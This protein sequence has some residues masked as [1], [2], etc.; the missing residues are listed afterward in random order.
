MCG[1][2]GFLELNHI[3][4]PELAEQ[5]LRTMC[6]EMEHRGPDDQGTYSD[7]TGAGLG[8]VRLSIIDLA[9]GHQPLCNEDGSCWVALNGEIYNFPGLRPELERLGHTF[10]THCDTEAIVHA[11]EEWGDDC[12]QHLGGMF[13]F[14]IWDSRNRRLFVAR[15]RLGKKPLYYSYDGD[16]F[17]FSSEIKS[18]V[19]HP[20]VTA[21]LDPEA[22][23]VYMTFGYI[24]GPMT[25]FE[26]INKLLPGHT[27]VLDAA[28]QVTCRQYWDVP[29]IDPADAAQIDENEAAH[30]VRR[31]LEAAVKDRLLADVPVGVFLSGG[32]DFEPGHGFNEA[33]QTRPVK[34]FLRQFSRR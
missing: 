17:V 31:L 12:V 15:D 16:T 26:N 20:A 8:A 22:L 21:R 33:A 34:I 4:P 11:Y 27:L 10:R 30:E 6:H 9:G 24:P 19:K 23:D 14:A 29:E 28:C 7:G 5:T 1:I 18:L 3:T 13:A 32:L 25:V 2:C